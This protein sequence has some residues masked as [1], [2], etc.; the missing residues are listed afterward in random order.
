MIDQNQIG[1]GLIIAFVIWIART[2]IKTRS[3]MDCAFIKIRYLEFQVKQLM[4]ENHD[5]K[6][7][8]FYGKRLNGQ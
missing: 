1:G 2:V 4:G 6:E 5:L 7:E 3:D 8:R